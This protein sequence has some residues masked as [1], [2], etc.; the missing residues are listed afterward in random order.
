MKTQLTPQERKAAKAAKERQHQLDK[1]FKF[2]SKQ[3]TLMRERYYNA[4]ISFG[5]RQIENAITDMEQQI[6][7]HGMTDNRKHWLKLRMDRRNYITTSSCGWL[8]DAEEVFDSRL[9]KMSTR[10]EE[11]GFLNS[12]LY[13][14]VANVNSEDSREFS[15]E[16]D[17]TKYEHGK[18]EPT[19]VGTAHARLI[20]VE[21][22]EKTSHWRF[23]CTKRK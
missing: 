18:T 14:K 12:R 8:K 22:T 19:K 16:I 3:T 5:T 21:C 7:E 15:F 2:L 11:F 1:A 20:W 17:I 13:M 6:A 23:I 9:I 10:L 4:A